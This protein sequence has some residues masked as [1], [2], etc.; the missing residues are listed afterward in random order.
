MT[1]TPTANQS[2]GPQVSANT[3]TIENFAF[4]PASLTVKVG[5]TVTFVNKDTTGHSATADDGSFDTGVFS[6]GGSEK[7]TL[8]KAGTFTYHCT[9]HPSMKGTIVVE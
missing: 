6:S 4:S 8:T 3:V 7:V 9:A 2:G 1:P 5:D